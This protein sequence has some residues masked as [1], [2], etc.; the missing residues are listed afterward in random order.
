M[1]W[2]VNCAAWPPPGCALRFVFSEQEPGR[3]LLSEQG[4]A[5]ARRLMADGRLQL[6][7][8]AGAD[9]TFTRLAARQALYQRLDQ[10]LSDLPAT[11]PSP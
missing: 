2:P 9:H 8:V 7:P 4:G 11:P 1:T 3:T 5:M 6:H 10:L